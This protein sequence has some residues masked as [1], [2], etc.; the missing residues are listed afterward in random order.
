MH[1]HV[2]KS[3]P[4]QF[5]AICVDTKRADVRKDD[6]GF[7]VGDALDFQEWDPKNSSYT[8]R[9]VRRKIMHIVRGPDFAIP[10]GYVVMSLGFEKEME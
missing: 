9:E 8:G 3:W 4:E 1:V 2:L 6:R 7:K 5:G 10:E